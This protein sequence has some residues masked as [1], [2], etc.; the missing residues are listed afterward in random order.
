MG[1][2]H[3][4]VAAAMS[5]GV[6]SSV[7]AF[8]LKEQGYN[9]IGMFM[10]NWEEE[11]GSCPATKDYED[12]LEVAQILKIPLY[13]VN[14]TKEY[15]DRVFALCLEEYKLGLTPNPDIL[16]NRE[17]KFEALLTKGLELGADYLATGHYCQ[18]VVQDGSYRLA[19]GED[20]NKDQSYFL[21]TLKE[22][23]LKRVLFPVG[24]LPK[25]E[26]RELAKK[27]GLPT[28]EKK[29]ST[30]ICFI[31]KRNFRQFLSTYITSTPGDFETSEGKKVGQHEGIAYYT[32]GQRKTGIG[33]PGEPWYVVGKDAKRNVVIVEQGATHPRLYRKSLTAS[34]VT[35]VGEP[36]TAPFTCTA[37]IRYRS[38]DAT[39][40]VLPLKDNLIEVIFDKPEK[41]VTPRQ[42]IVFYDGPICLGGAMIQ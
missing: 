10:R 36:P 26:V 42:S 6:D 11:D 34:D 38:A 13:T 31:G 12:A 23:I 35:W 33:G 7:A 18:I 14:F 32:I 19:R 24:H 29:D 41:A 16:C 1:Y 40:T 15:W 3:T 5:G 22:K 2:S 8:L 4:T 37:K 9:V 30:G 39:C 27:A 28:A 17:I 25:Q 20:E 21:Y